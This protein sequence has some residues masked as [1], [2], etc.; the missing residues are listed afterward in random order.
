MKVCFRKEGILC[1]SA[2]RK[3]VLVYRS[4]PRKKGLA[5][6]RLKGK[7][8]AKMKEHSSL[9]VCIRKEGIGCILYECGEKGRCSV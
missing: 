3:R 8:E 5:R 1:R 4:V 7:N 2:I 6:M 9:Q